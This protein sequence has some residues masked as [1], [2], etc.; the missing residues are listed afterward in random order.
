LS[1]ARRVLSGE[2]A[3]ANELDLPRSHVER[4]DGAVAAPSVKLVV[5][6]EGINIASSGELLELNAPPVTDASVEN[7]NLF[8]SIHDLF[9]MNP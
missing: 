6:A 8:A 2:Q 3:E 9:P 1:E 4:D 5:A 7:G